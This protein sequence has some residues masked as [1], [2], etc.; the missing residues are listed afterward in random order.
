[1]L[2][3]IFLPEKIGTHRIL[4]QRIIGLSVHEDVVRLV[5]VHVKRSKSV[6]QQLLTENIESG[7]EDTYAERASQALKKIMTYVTSYDQIRICVP[8]SMLVL[9]ELTLQ[10]T[11]PTKIRMVLEYEI[12]TMLPFAV[13]EAVIDFIVTKTQKDPQQAQILVAAVRSQDLETY[14]NMFTQAGIDPTHITIDLFALYGLYQQIPEYAVQASHATAMIELGHHSTRIAFIQDGQLRLSRSLP[15]GIATII[16]F[17]SQ[18]ADISHDDVEKILAT[19]GINGIPDETL[20]RIVQKHFVLLLNDIQ[21]TLNSF[22]LKLNFY[23]GVNKVLFTG[24]TQNIKNLMTFCSDTIQIPCE[25]FDCQK[26]L[27]SAVVLSNQSQ[28]QGQLNAYA[29]VLGVAL[30][31]VEQGD[32][33]LRRKQFAFQR[34]GLVVK[35]LATACLITICM[36]VTVGTMGYFHLARLEQEATQLEQDEINKIRKE[37]IFEKDRFPKS[38]KLQIVLREAEKIVR[39]KQEIW[40]P[41]AQKRIRP[42]ELWSELVRIINK[43]QFDVTIK[44]VTFTTE[45]RGWDRDKDGSI[46]QDLGTAK[47]EVEGLFKS[48]TG[49]H[50]QSFGLFENRF[51]DSAMLQ[52]IVHPDAIAPAVDGG[53]D[54]NIKMKLKEG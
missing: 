16:K 1:M 35:Q 8:A 46:K 36:F 45:E 49:E 19:Q 11:D 47:V 32:F 2:A 3:S 17:I 23:E 54:F 42:L 27:N 9:K 20:S 28:D 21:F 18:E 10:F 39:E 50:F 26:L 12:E 53:V 38:P 44:E 30:P 34:H 48:K 31:S 22:S 40:A 6:I 33:D 5:Q 25:V 7:T 24:Y 37:E 14:L 51:K 29:T 4:A 41:F 43:R 52:F 13:N 15:R